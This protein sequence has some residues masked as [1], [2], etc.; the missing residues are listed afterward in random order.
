M[1]HITQ[2]LV[3]MCF[4][5]EQPSEVAEVAPPVE[6]TATK[7]D[8]AAG[9]SLLCKIGSGLDHAFVR[10]DLHGKYVFVFLARLSQTLG[11]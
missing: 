5:Q 6:V 11:V 4:Q 7:E 10:V 3:I 1:V 8:I 2:Y 9:L